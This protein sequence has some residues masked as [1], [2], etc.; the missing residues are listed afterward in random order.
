MQKQALRTSVQIQAQAMKK[1][2]SKHKR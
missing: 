1:L 2:Q